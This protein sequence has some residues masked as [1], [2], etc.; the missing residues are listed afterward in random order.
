MFHNPAPAPTAG[1]PGARVR[2]P[3]RRTPASRRLPGTFATGDGA[4]RPMNGPIPLPAAPAPALARSNREPGFRENGPA[5]LTG[6]HRC[7]SHGPSAKECPDSALRAAGLSAAEGLGP[8]ESPNPGQN[9]PVPDDPEQKT[10]ENPAMEALQQPFTLPPPLGR[11]CA[12]PP[13]HLWPRPPPNSLSLPAFVA[14]QRLA[15][16]LIVAW[17]GALLPSPCEVPEDQVPWSHYPRS[18]NETT[19]TDVYTLFAPT[20]R[21]TGNH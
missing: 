21:K 11:S 7:P 6:S 18:S 10:P 16:I 19:P 4:V 2:P 15:L 8:P 5:R 14:T 17:Q 20:S 9:R 3:S 1:G 13:S 12:P